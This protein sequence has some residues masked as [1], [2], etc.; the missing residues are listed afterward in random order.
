GKPRGHGVTNLAF[1][2][3]SPGGSFIGYDF[4]KAYLPDVTLTGS[5]QTVALFELDGYFASDITIYENQAGL[6]HLPLKNVYVDGFTG[7]P[8]LGNGEVALDIEMAVAFAPGLS[9]IIVYEGLN[10]GD[11]TIVTHLLQRIASDNSA[12]Q[13]S[14]S[15]LLPDNPTWDQIYQQYALQGQSF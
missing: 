7:T 9:N 13:I 14:S 12:K 5:G 3:S 1:T 2:G 8:G 11:D 10:N 4:R 6:P 15:W